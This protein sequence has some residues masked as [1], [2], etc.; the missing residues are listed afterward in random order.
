MIEQMLDNL[1]EPVKDTSLHTACTRLGGITPWRY[2]IM[3]GERTDHLLV[4]FL[5][6][7]AFVK[8]SGYG[9]N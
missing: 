8:T 5:V 7:D 2:G 3:T 1:I 4:E 6:K 9:K